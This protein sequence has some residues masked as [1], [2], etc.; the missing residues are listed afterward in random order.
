[1][2]FEGVDA[3]WKEVATSSERQMGSFVALWISDFLGPPPLLPKKLV[4]LRN[5]C[6]HK[7]RIPPES[8][9]KAYGEAVLRTEV[10]GI[11]T[12]RNCFDSELDYDDFVE[13]HI[14]RPGASEPHLPSFVGNTVLSGMWRSNE[15]QPDE[16]E[17]ESGEGLQNRV[18]QKN[19]TDATRLTMDRALRT[20]AG[21]RSLGLRR[22]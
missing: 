15:Y 4:E 5:D 10:S 7:G 17:S 21:L 18:S 8:E 12:L 1:V 11:V 22:T 6:V 20:F 16:D 3:W 2:S 14:I 9:A 13:H 19:T